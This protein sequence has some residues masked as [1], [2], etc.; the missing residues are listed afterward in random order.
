[1]WQEQI[2][3]S[4]G[5]GS[6]GVMIKLEPGDSGHGTTYANQTHSQQ[7]DIYFKGTDTSKQIEEKYSEVV[8]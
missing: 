7:H 8:N 1:M 2:P 6:W 5:R 4:E 3:S